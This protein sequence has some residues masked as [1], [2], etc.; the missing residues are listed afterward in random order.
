[1]EVGSEGIMR[2]LIALLSLLSLAWAG[3]E[4]VWVVR[5]QVLEKGSVVEYI[6]TRRYP[7][8]SE[9]ALEQLIG[10]LSRPARP[11]RFI[12]DPQKGWIAVQ[13]LG[14]RFDTEAVRLTYRAALEAS[15]PSFVLPVTVEQPRPSVHDLLERGI[16]ELVGEGTTNFAGSPPSRVHNIRLASSRFDGVQIPPGTVFSFNRAL[17]PVTPATGYQKAWVIRG[18]QTVWD[19]GGGVCQVCTTLFRAAYFSSLPIVERHPHSYQ[20]GYY[21][22]TGLDAT[23]APPK[24]LRFKNDTPGYLLIQT[25]IQGQNLTFRFFGTKDREVT[26]RG[27][28]ILWRTP[29][30]P[31]R[32]IY[33][34]TL[35]PGYRRQIDFAAEGALVRVYR[36]V[37]LQS[38][39]VRQDVL[40]S[41]YKAWGAVYL[42]GP[43]R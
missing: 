16:V 39:A 38:G 22:P 23:T 27:P 26:W 5:E 31:T 43:R 4:A 13:K 40:E 19:V 3:P 10:Q 20:V 36:T 1:M 6:G 28:V 11:A 8:P 12:L 42:V 2:A 9:A 34:A 32:Y 30:L 14:Y 41:R 37:R 17:G 33:D 35:P 29:P 18:D 7:V 15:K 21:K 25:S 24:D